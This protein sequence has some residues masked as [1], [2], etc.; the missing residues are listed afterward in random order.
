MIS[1]GRYQTDLAQKTYSEHFDYNY[2]APISPALYNTPSPAAS[3][4]RWETLQ[5]V[6]ERKSAEY[7]K[8]GLDTRYKVLFLDRHGQ[9]YGKEVVDASLLRYDVEEVE[10]LYEV[11]AIVGKRMAGKGRT[12]LQH[13][14]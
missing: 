2:A 13:L 4:E 3:P 7:I 8:N 11:Q 5:G 14:F 9:R 1:E 10:P 12:S 6:I